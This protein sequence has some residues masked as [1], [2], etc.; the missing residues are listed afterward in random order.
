MAFIQYVLTMQN[1]EEITVNEWQAQG[2]TLQYQGYRIF[3]RDSGETDKPVLILIHGLPTS[4][5]DWHKL[6]QPLCKRF[7]LIALDMLGLGFSDKPKDFSYSLLKQADLYETLLNTLSIDSF[8]ILAH[9]YGDSVAQ[10]LLARFVENNFLFKAYKIESICFLNG[11]LFPEAHKALFT[12]KILATPLGHLMMR[13][14]TEKTMHKGFNKIF[15]PKTAPSNQDWQ[16]FWYL[17]NL[18]DGRIVLP[19]LMG[20]MKERRRFRERWLSAMENTRVP[21][22][23]IVGPADPISGQSLIDR[24]REL[25][26]N[27]NVTV[28]DNIGHYPHIENPEGVLTSFTTFQ[29]NR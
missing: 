7:R 5:W 29:N 25:F 13:L 20:Y 6:W 23:L 18:Q 11:G 22:K 12:Q 21:Q 8:H 16:G 28:L 27:A 3:Y 14:A 10:E 19:K 26:P 15:G 24:Y 4:S 2:S 1:S 9:D 17:M